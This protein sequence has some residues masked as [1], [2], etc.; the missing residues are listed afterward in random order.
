MSMPM[1]TKYFTVIILFNPTTTTQ[2][3]NRN[4]YNFYFVYVKTE[5]KRH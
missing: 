1:S 2:D 3:R 4:I 5:D